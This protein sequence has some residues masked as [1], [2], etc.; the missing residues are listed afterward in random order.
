[1]NP[2]TPSHEF[3]TLS[4][5]IHI[6]KASMGPSAQVI[7]SAASPRSADLRQQVHVLPYRAQVLLRYAARVGGGGSDLSGATIGGL[8]ASRN[9]V[10][11]VRL[12][13]LIPTVCRM[14]IEFNVF[15]VICQ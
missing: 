2:V 14:R 7:K 1:M 8:A 10:T 6:Q 5:R 3:L 15:L 4:C 9:V 11:I 13:L 12:A